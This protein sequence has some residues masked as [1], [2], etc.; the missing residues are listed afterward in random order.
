MHSRCTEGNPRYED[1]GG[2]GI[3]ICER[4]QSFTAFLE[5]MGERPSVAHSIDREENN[6]DYTPD[7]CKWSTM[8]VQSRNKRNTNSVTYAGATLCITDWAKKLGMSG[9]G[10]KYRLRNF[11]LAEAMTREKPPWMRNVD[12]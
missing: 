7:N 1:R 5:D 12:V 10:L 4:W 8:P 3:K 2:R 11:P 9:N 6:G